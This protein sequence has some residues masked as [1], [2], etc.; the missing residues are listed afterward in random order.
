MSPAG[1]RSTCNSEH[2]P[3]GPVSPIIQKL[4]VLVPV[5]D[6]DRGIEPGGGEEARPVIVR[7]LVEL[8][9]FVRPG[10]VNGGVE[11]SRRKT[12]SPND[13][14][15]GPFDR[16]LLEVIAKAPVA[17]HLE[18]GVVI[19]IEPDV[20]EVVV[21]APGADAFLGVGGARRIEGRPLLAEKD[22]HELVHARRW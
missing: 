4:S 7:F 19:G 1:V 16:F 2:G 13:Q 17:E 21:L 3:H 15:P 8:A 18:K 20:V 11:A 10:L 9:R 6:V 14:L 22:R 12:P 5:D